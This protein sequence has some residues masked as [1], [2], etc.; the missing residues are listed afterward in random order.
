M[1]RTIIGA[2]LLCG[3]AFAQEQVYHI[4]PPSADFLAWYDTQKLLKVV[5]DLQVTGKIDG[6]WVPSP[7][8]ATGTTNAYVCAP[9]KAVASYQTGLHVVMIVPF[10]NTTAV[11]VAVSGLAAKAITKQGGNAVALAGGEIHTGQAVDLVYDG[12]EFQLQSPAAN[13]AT[14]S[15][16]SCAIT[17]IAG[18]II[19]AATCSP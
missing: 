17:A 9:A 16:S 19:T 11:T 18:G 5:G 15:G 6:L 8:T 1:K 4:G 12:T 7:C 13:G 14:A 2:L 10:T 3:V